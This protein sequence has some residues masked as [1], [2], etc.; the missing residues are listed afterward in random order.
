MLLLQ[1]QFAA[2][3]SQ[4]EAGEHCTGEQAVTFLEALFTSLCTNS[5]TTPA[6]KA[7]SADEPHASITAASDSA[8]AAADG[9]WPSRVS[10]SPPPS[11][12]LPGA[13]LQPEPPGLANQAS[14]AGAAAAA[15]GA[16][17]VAAAQNAAVSQL[18]V[19]LNQLAPLYLCEPA[20]DVV[21]EAPALAREASQRYA[22]ALLERELAVLALIEAMLDDDMQAARQKLAGANE[23]L[24]ARRSELSSAE[25]EHSRLVAEGPA[26]HRKKDFLDKATKEAEHREKLADL[27]AKIDAAKAAIAEDEVTAAAADLAAAD[28]QGD[29][30]RVREQ[31]RQIAARK[32]NLEDLNAQLSA[33][34]PPLTEAALAA[35]VSSSAAIAGA[36]L[37][38][39]SGPGAAAAAAAGSSP[40]SCCP[41]PCGSGRSSTSVS[42]DPAA[43]STAAELGWSWR[44]QRLECLMYRVLWVA[45][46]VKLFQAQYEPRGKQYELLVRASKWVK[47]RCDEYDLTFQAAAEDL[48]NLRSR[49]QQLAW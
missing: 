34:V 6:S 7:G 47:E 19:R 15:V 18:Q 21:R 2:V 38:M 23:R 13:P 30:A 40:C 1:T 3:R 16:A 10:L 14:A 42:S 17:S 48:S 39:L 9:A 45:E 44:A 31:A 43:I 24:L 33:P 27:K 29:L 35:A 25:S 8:V 11:L 5:S 32:K 36:G 12:C 41:L 22:R 20:V 26:S 28:A 49:V 46:A 4:E 37:G